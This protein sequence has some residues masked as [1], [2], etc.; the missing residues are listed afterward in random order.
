MMVMVLITPHGVQRS[1]VEGSMPEG[2]DA[3]HFYGQ[4]KPLLQ[5]LDEDVK[6]LRKEMN[7]TKQFKEVP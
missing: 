5:R 4:L 7:S 2:T 3:L 6:V 1:I